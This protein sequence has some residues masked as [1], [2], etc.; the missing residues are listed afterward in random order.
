MDHHDEVVIVPY[1]DGPY[2]VR[3]PAALR[4]QDGAEITA[5]RATF[6]L[7]RCGK[8]RQR[9]FCDGS[10]QVVRFRAPSGR[11]DRRGEPAAAGPPVA[12]RTRAP[13]ELELIAIGRQLDALRDRLSR[14]S[15]VGDPLRGRALAETSRL[16][17]S[18]AAWLE[19][20]ATEG[21]AA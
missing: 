7:C 20:A 21:E 3:G 9:P 13:A 12:P 18:A 6:A 16:L 8:S 19:R 15:D 14:S 2:L 1:C 11:E 5:G 17:A 4:D 10:H